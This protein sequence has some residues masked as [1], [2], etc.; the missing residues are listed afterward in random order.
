MNRKERRL[1]GSVTLCQSMASTNTAAMGGWK[2][3]EMTWTYTKSCALWNCW[4]MGIHTI[5][6]AKSNTTKDLNKE[7]LYFVLCTLQCKLL[8]RHAS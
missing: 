8:K 5:E 1:T 3:A 4:M 2:K 6:I 7:K